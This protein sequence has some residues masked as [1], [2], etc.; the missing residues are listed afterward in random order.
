MEGHYKR[1]GF[2]ENEDDSHVDKMNRLNILHLACRNGHST[3]RTEAGNS[4]LAWIK[5]KSAYISPNLRTLV[6]R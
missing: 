1:L 6:Y 2:K 5:D 4:F 3:C